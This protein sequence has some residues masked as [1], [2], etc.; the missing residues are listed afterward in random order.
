MKIRRAMETD[1]P[2]ILALYAQLEQ[3]REST[4]SLSE[5]V[6]IFRRMESYSNYHI[7]I[8]EQ[9]GEA[10]GAFSLA[11]MDNL[12]H[13][14]AKSGL[15]EDVV[16]DEKHRGKGIGKKMMQYAMDLCKKGSCYK[17]CL[18]S[19]IKRESAH[20]FYESLGFQ[21]HGYSFQIKLDF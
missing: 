6:E 18:S 7:Y 10:L 16:V 19:N 4:V 14:G 3:D 13:F 17:A 1:I 5:A 2:A 15:I 12:A 9:Q 11:I 20:D 21:K 8:A